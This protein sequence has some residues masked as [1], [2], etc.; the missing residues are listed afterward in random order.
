ML[1]IQTPAMRC[2]A[3]LIWLL[4][5]PAAAQD[6]QLSLP[7]GTATL[8]RPAQTNAPAPLIVLLHGSSQDGAALR[9]ITA[10]QWQAVAKTHGAALLWPDGMNQL[11]NIGLGPAP[12]RMRKRRD[13]FAFLQA[14]IREAAKR[15]PIDAKRI[16][17]VGFSMGGQMALAL[18]CAAPHQFAG[19]ASVAHPVPQVLVP[20]CTA[21]PPLRVALMHGKRDPLV[22]FGG[23]TIPS[24]I[25]AGLEVLSLTES[26]ALFERRNRCHK[27]PCAAPVL[28]LPLEAHGHTWPGGT[29]DFP[30]LYLGA[31]RPDVNA[32]QIIW[33]FFDRRT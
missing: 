18:G 11:W 30:A 5:L 10:G 12:K 14:M 21:G 4:A 32:A 17:L 28:A 26:R 15:T 6:L 8:T 29:R 19:V 31:Q 23:G 3:L 9:A 13:D 24:G 27:G 1:M 25:D 33:A 7:S 2:I 16:Y 20:S 22:P